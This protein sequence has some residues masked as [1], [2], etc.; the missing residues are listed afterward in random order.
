MAQLNFDASRVEPATGFDAVP[1][2]WY[3]VMVDQSELKPTN[4][5]AGT[6]LNFRYVILDGQYQGRKIFH[7]LNLQNA[8]PQTVEIAFKQLSALAHAVGILQ[9]G[10]STQLHNIPLKIKVK[11]RPADGK[12]DEQND[13]TQWKNINEQVGAAPAAQPA[14][15]GAPAPGAGGWTP[16]AQQAPAPQ[17]APQG[18]GAPPATAAQ[19]ATP[20]GAPPPAQQQQPQFAPPAQQQQPPA[21]QQAPAGWTPPATPQPWAN[22]QPQQQQAPQQQA[23]PAAAQPAQPQGPNPAQGAAPPWHRPQ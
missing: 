8:N 23:A 19:P 20:W 17:Q 3:N 18:W 4:D 6:R 12:Y 14:F 5:G 9:V 16:P 11:V 13:I 15:G 22:G 7:G 21:Q 2:G 10:D 1:A